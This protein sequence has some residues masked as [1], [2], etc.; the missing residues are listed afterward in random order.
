MDKISKVLKK[1][2]ENER[3]VVR[4]ILK[5]IIHNDTKGMDIKK[6]KGK[7]DLYRIRKGDL[8]IIYK[9]NKT[10]EIIITD[11]GRRNDN[12]YKFL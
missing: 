12:T 5:K 8:R 2:S 4:E 9:I 6:L 10:G 1:L 7:S 3:E 11:I